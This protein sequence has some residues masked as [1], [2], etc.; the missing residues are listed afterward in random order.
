M[1]QAWQKESQLMR[2]TTTHY[3]KKPSPELLET[4]QNKKKNPADV[5]L[6]L[7]GIIYPQNNTIM[8]DRTFV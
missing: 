5:R 7:L 6:V 2:I 3:A 1:K 4:K 8:K